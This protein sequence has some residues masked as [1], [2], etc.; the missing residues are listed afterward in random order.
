MATSEANK[1]AIAKNRKTIFDIEAQVMANKALVYQSRSM[2]EENRLMIMSNY[3]AAFMGNR[4]LANA[5]TDEI[6]SNRA[7]ILQ[8]MDTDGDVQENYVNAQTNKSALDFLRHRS[9]LNSSVL[10]IS[11]K[12]A[13]IN[14][15][16]V[17]IN[18]EIMDA[19]A[20]I[21]AFNG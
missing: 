3:S 17:E 18:R 7:A 16:L 2:I 13:A 6:F 4:Q 15:Q 1:A 21:V 12:M 8:G 9:S 20:K 5:N 14:S 10:N 19:N 11:E